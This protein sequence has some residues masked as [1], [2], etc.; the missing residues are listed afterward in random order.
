MKKMKTKN[1]CL[2]TSLAIIAMLM[3]SLGVKA[4]DVSIDPES[5]S[6]VTSV[7]RNVD[8]GYILGLSALW[9]HEQLALSMT[10]TDRDGVTES[11]DILEPS[12]V[13]GER[14]GML[15]IVGG[16]RPS[17]F[18]VSL[19]K[20]YR[21]TGYDLVLVNNL[22]GVDMAPNKDLDDKPHFHHLNTRDGGRWG[23]NNEF[24]GANGLG[25]MR[26]YETKPWQTNKT[27]SWQ[28]QNHWNNGGN[29]ESRYI[30]P[31]L[32]VNNQD[33]QIGTE[34]LATATADDG[35]IN[36]NNTEADTN[37]EYKM[38]RHSNDMGNQLYFR[39]VKD[40]SFYGLSIKSFIIYF[41]AEGTFDAPIG[42]AAADVAHR[43]VSSPF[44]TNKTDIGVM[45]KRYQEGHENDEAYAFF[46][47]QYDN[48]TPINAYN[49][50]YQ[51]R[52][53]KEGRPYE[54]ESDNQGTI[55]PHIYP[56]KVDNQNLF[57][58]EEDTY[59]VEPPVSVH[60]SSGLEAPIGYRIV[61]AKFEY[62]WGSDVQASQK[63]VNGY[64][65][66]YTSGSTT[67]YLNDEL[68]FTTNEYIWLRDNNNN[69][70]TD[71]GFNK[72]YLACNGSGDT[73]TLSFSNKADGDAARWNLR[74][75]SSGQIYYQSDNRTVYLKGTT[76]SSVTP[77]LSTGTSGA[78]TSTS[79][80][81]TYNIPGFSAGTYK[82]NIYD[83]TGNS[84]EKTIDVTQAL[85]TSTDEEGNPANFYELK[86]LNNDAVKFSITNLQSGKKALVRVTLQLQA[87]DPYINNMQVNCV[88]LPKELQMSQKFTASNFKVS[89]GSFV[90]YVP[91]D[92]L[93][94]TMDISFSELYSDYGDY[95]YWGETES[96]TNA[97]YSYVTSSYFNPI[98]GN[99]NLGL[100][101]GAY[102]PNSD[103]TTKVITATA[104]NVRYKFNNAENLGNTGSG[105]AYLEEYPFSVK[106]YL[107]NYADPD[108]ATGT[109]PTIAK[110]EECHVKAGNDENPQPAGK[111]FVFIADETRYNIAPTYN[112]QHRDYA[113]YRMDVKAVAK[114]YEPVLTWTKVYENALYTTKDENGKEVKGEKAQFGLKL[115]TT[116]A[117][118]VANGYLTVK[119]I[120][121]TI[122]AAITAEKATHTGNVPE[123]KDQIL[124][125]D[126]SSLLA[127][128][129]YVK[130]EG[131]TTPEPSTLEGL[132]D[133]M[134]AN[135]LIYL[136]K[137]TTTTLDNFAY[138]TADNTFRAGNH[139][140]LTDKQPFYSKYDIQIAPANWATYTR[141]ISAAE[142]GQ[143][144]NATIMLPFTL[145]VKNGLHTNPEETP[146][147]SFYVNTM[148]SGAT[149][150]LATGSSI[151]HGTAFFDKITGTVAEA[152]T[153]YMIHVESSNAS[154]NDNFSFIV[155]EKGAKII[156]TN[157]LGENN[158][159]G[160]GWLHT[161][162]EDVSASF[163]K[164]NYKFTNKATFSGAKFDR[165]ESE[166]VFYFAHNMYLDL[167]TLS[168]K[169][170]EGNPNQYL[171]IYPFRGVY[172]YTRT[173]KPGTTGNAK[174]MH[175]FDISFDE[176]PI[177]GIATWLDEVE[178]T[179]PDLMI[180][181]DRGK[182]T[183][184]ASR[185]QDVVIRS[186]NGMV[187]KNTNVEAGNTTT[188]ALPAGI[189]VVNNTKITVK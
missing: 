123:S 188:V 94:E 121:E 22:V 142:N 122:D 40:Y 77:T 48:V 51:E 104:G 95:T 10:G 43:V 20:G 153:P 174:P 34:V 180:R 81:R 141:S 79:F 114:T 155:A 170:S 126:A 138:L 59:F 115:T 89:G 130:K 103:Y 107:S 165:A 164:Y 106:T 178:G 25:T 44:N 119:Q 12:T 32:N 150:S 14:N 139:I 83:K 176:M 84:I 187:V 58:F 64:T 70:Y 82:L 57:A 21:I 105:S 159:N 4:Q 175:S 85:T 45:E 88:N 37:K 124:Y 17:F 100:Y 66:T 162:E 72:R 23:T 65:I 102:T 76:D 60:T 30:N 173:Q 35:D 135:S 39:L 86:G 38:S 168:L 166:D 157:I 152:N 98:N 129:N 179:K 184:T 144:E 109:T 117:G 42:P 71:D 18:T 154:A 185:S 3:M 149:M 67:Y 148:K 189:Y 55:Y 27:N 143:V 92:L 136:P 11:N 93:G 78:A 182:L 96:L 9:R 53:V 140:V 1:K 137:A 158:P 120:Q 90:F 177:A 147:C 118:Q 101:D 28:D 183:I 128:Y 171:Y 31:G 125:V 91:S 116:D 111:F 6:L 74:R 63:T 8:T 160:T 2:V 99:G 145:T 131:T 181:S 15:T 163:D 151:D 186:V 36:I 41:T 156:A 49:T 46:S 16:R 80:S 68:H 73:R 112:W 97:R 167:R 47:Y 75:N 26:F 54:L 161:G 132:K 113:F 7:P 50:I 52:A 29:A 127:V 33:K 87:L 169:D 172:T 134:G 69:F 19:P 146:A 62:L 61:G 5:G 110:F 56:V 13:F 24:D 133:G 108:A